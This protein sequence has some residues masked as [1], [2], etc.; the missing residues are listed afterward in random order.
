MLVA[1]ISAFLGSCTDHDLPDSARFSL[2]TQSV[3]EWKGFLKT[4][5]FNN[6]TIKV[7]SDD[8]KVENGKVV[9]GSFKIPVS[10]IINLNLPLS[11][12][13]NSWCTT[14]KALTFLIWLCILM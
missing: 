12:S 7:E 10:S 14:F 11:R 13:R 2:N 4:G 6:G 8:I 3:A 5:Y 1:V 9:G